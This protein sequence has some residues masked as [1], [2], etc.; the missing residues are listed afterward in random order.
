VTANTMFVSRPVL[1]SMLAAIGR[2]YYNADTRP[3]WRPRNADGPF[4]RSRQQ[5]GGGA[6]LRAGWLAV[7][8]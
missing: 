2:E 6:K 1:E 3:D 7:R 8:R 4:E 5:A